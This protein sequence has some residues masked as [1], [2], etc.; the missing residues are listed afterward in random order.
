MV[1]ARKERGR[2]S[3]KGGRGESWARESYMGACLKDN[4]RCVKECEREKDR[5]RER[6]RVADK[7]KE[8]ITT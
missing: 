7:E 3:E 4:Q 6:V 1:F 5:V 8:S 2:V